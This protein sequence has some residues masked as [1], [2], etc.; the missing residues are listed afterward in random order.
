MKLILPLF[1]FCL[2]FT[3][4]GQQSIDDVMVFNLWS[5]Y[6]PE[7][8]TWSDW[9]ANDEVFLL[10]FMNEN[11]IA[12]CRIGSNIIILKIK[13]DVP[14]E[15][16]TS[17]SGYDYKEYKATGDFFQPYT[18]RFYDNHPEYGLELI[19]GAVRLRFAKR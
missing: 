2:T 14:I 19:T 5:S 3:S 15:Q 6:D 11:K 7:T 8:G 13:D 4:F 18:L 12:R 9:K 1:L 17:A 16:G 10:N